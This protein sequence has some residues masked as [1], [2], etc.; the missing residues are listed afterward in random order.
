MASPAEFATPIIGRDLSVLPNKID[1]LGYLFQRAVIRQG[2]NRFKYDLFLCHEPIMK[3]KG[4][5]VQEPTADLTKKSAHSTS[6]K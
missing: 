6:Q 3:L 5:I 4:Q 1:S 2:A